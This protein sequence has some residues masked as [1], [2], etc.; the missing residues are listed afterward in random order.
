[1]R[2]E[3]VL[4]SADQ[5]VAWCVCSGLVCTLGLVI[6]EDALTALN[7]GSACVLAGLRRYVLIGS[8]FEPARVCATGLADW[9]S[10]W[11]AVTKVIL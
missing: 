2:S 10:Q 3:V 4:S 11:P 9:L 6:A 7:A 5:V 8:S 1:M